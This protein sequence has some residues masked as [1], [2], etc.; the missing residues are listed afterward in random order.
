[1]LVFTCDSIFFVFVF[2]IYL[3][4]KGH[5]P[6]FQGERLQLISQH[7]VGVQIV[8]LLRRMIRPQHPVHPH[9]NNPKSS[10]THYDCASVTILGNSSV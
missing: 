1:M 3:G 10:P 8:L 9:E 7:M 4:S 5:M 6:L 2:V